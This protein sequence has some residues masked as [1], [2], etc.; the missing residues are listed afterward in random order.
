MRP[1]FTAALAATLGGGLVLAASSTASADIQLTM[2]GGRVTLMAKDV[3]VRQILAEWAR[4]GQTKIVNAERVPGGPVTLQL[5]DVSEQQALDVLLRTVS[6]YLAA[7]RAIVGANLS[8]FDRIMVMPVS[9]T[10]PPSAATSAPP[11]FAQPQ[12]NQQAP[13]FEDQ[14]NTPG[15]PPQNRGPVFNAFPPPQFFNPQQV[16]PGTA[17]ATGP[18]FQ[19]QQ[20]TFQQPAAPVTAAPASSVAYP[21]A[22]TSAIPAGVAFPGMVVP[23]PQ[24]PPGQQQGQQPGQPAQPRR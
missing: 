2:Q 23:A 9:A 24:P 12:F 5:T 1:L 18:Q 7:P 11:P 13:P 20:P 21:G 15:T 19:P 22:P 16:P 4:V 14:D 3:T 17:G 10:P 8:V 6:G